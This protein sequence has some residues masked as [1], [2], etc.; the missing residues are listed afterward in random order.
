L[1]QPAY[2]QVRRLGDALGDRRLQSLAAFDTGRVLIDQREYAA[3]IAVNQQA[4]ALATDPHI[5]VS[6]VFNLGRAYLEHGDVTQAMPAL[7]QAARLYEQMQNRSGQGWAMSHLSRAHLLRGDL[8]PALDLAHQALA[9]ARAG[10]NPTTVATAL[11]TLGRIALVRGAL[12]EA[13]RH[14]QE[15]LQMQTT[16]ERRSMVGALSLDLAQ[17]AH[18]QGNPQAVTTHLHEAL[19]LFNALHLP[20]WV[21]HTV[22]LASELGV[23]LTP[24]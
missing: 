5:A 3:A 12:A 24:S 7:E 19:T 6:A 1:A 14:F 21:E 17:L 15:A 23:S 10:H 20:R 4:V 13:E 16:T 18:V 8:P 9:L 2:D 22:Q 11:R